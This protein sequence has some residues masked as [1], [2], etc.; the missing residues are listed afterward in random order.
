MRH[1]LVLALAVILVTG[2]V[3]IA[4]H[5][6]SDVPTGHLAHDAAEWMANRQITLGCA[7]GIFCPDGLVTRAQMALFMQRMGAAV[8][9]AFLNASATPGA[10]DIDAT[11]VVCQTT[12]AFSSMYP[13]SVVARARISVVAGAGSASDFFMSPVWSLDGGMSWSLIGAGFSSTLVPNSRTNVGID[14]F[15]TIVV[16]QSYLF[17]VRLTRT[18]GTLDASNSECALNIEIHNRNGTASPF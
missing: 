2:G 7:V 4:S 9:P 10:L 16:G 6:F 5:N 17:G 12:P 3:A 11:P 13:R 1:I 15:A 18:S 8:S 14:A